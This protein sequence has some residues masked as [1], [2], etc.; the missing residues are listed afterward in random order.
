MLAH[1]IT[2]SMPNLLAQANDQLA[3]LQ[4]QFSAIPEPIE[5]ADATTEI[6]QRLDGFCGDLTKSVSGLDV[7]DETILSNIPSYVQEN[8][9]AYLTLKKVIRGTA[10]DFRPYTEHE[11]HERILYDDDSDDETAVE[12]DSASST[13]AS[14]HGAWS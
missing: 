3:S 1:E 13:A 7:T 6:L 11:G 14:N 2:R 8:R 10:P 4:Q 5:N 9:N 12:S